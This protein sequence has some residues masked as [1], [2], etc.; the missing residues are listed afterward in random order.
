MVSSYM[1]NCPFPINRYRHITLAHGGGGRL[2]AQL[3]DEII[4]PAFTS[5]YLA[6]EHDGGIVASNASRLAITTDS[7]VVSPL[8][9]PGGNIGKLAIAGSIND[10]AMCGAAP[11][12]ITISLILEEGLS[13]ETLIRVV[14]EMAAEAQATGTPVVAGDIK[15][16]ERGSGDEIFVTTTA[17]GAVRTSTQISPRAIADG[18]V[19]LVTGD[20]GRHG[21]TLMVTRENLALESTELE[22]DCM[23]LIA[24]ILALIDAGITIHCMR[25]LTRG[26][27]ATALNE[28]ARSSGLNLNINEA[29]IMVAPEVTA[30]SELLGIDPLYAACE[31]RAAII[32]P[33][34]EAERALKILRTYEVT[35]GTYM[36]GDVSGQ[37][38]GAGIA[39]L[40]TKFGASRVLAMLSG[41]QLPRIC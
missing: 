14:H 37:R 3:L 19:I 40:R 10:L 22:S 28:L 1:Y 9:F 4:R 41:E 26:G 38:S 18:D 39:I 12:G 21:L 7:Y 17:I 25:D 24:P 8:F 11:L 2:T 31:G 6:E 15:V 27:L 20:V 34:G 33:E 35:A 23:S 16:V 30:A 36:A 13:T 29:Q 32:L 5:P